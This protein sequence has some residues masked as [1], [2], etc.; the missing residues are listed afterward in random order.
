MVLTAP[1][2][3]WVF[4]NAMASDKKARLPLPG[5]VGKSFT[6]EIIFKQT[7]WSVYSKEI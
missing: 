5:I 2:Y 4:C 6:E 7:L 3:S 1:S